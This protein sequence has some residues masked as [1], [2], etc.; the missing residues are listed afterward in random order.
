M[1]TPVITSSCTSPIAANGKVFPRISSI[2]R[3]GV[4]ISCSIVPISFSRTI[5][6]DVSVNVTN[7]MMLTMTPGTK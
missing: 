7:M 3:I 1:A 6:I 2:G 4:T 5:A